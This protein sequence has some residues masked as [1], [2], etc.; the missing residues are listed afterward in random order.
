MNCEEIVLSVVIPAYNMEKYIEKAVKSVLEADCNQCVEI[1]IVD[2]GSTDSTGNII[3]SLQ[4][5]YENIVAI[6]QKNAGHGGA[7]NTG[8]KESRG[9]YLKVL[10]SDDWMDPKALKALVDCL[11]KCKED[12]IL[13]DYN[14]HYISSHKI[15]NIHYPFTVEKKLNTDIFATKEF[16]SMHACTFK[17]E[18]LKSMPEKLHEH[19]FYVDM[20]YFLFPLFFVKS[21]RY[22]N[23]PVYQYRLERDEQSMS[24]EGFRKH[25]KDDAKVLFSLVD[26]YKKYNN[27]IVDDK[28]LNDYVQYRIF[29]MYYRHILKAVRYLKAEMKSSD[30]KKYLSAFDHKFLSESPQLYRFY[31]KNNSGIKWTSKMKL[32]LFRKTKFLFL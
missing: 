28:I 8:I 16:I 24:A 6:S 4:S 29:L 1:I 25:Y 14:E 21:V 3:A 26:Y 17:T 13:T 12:L 2:D 11:K 7:I 30:L 5:E 9:K 31:L 19:C 22:L 18:I 15:K 10:D 20:E 27:K 23:V 32:L